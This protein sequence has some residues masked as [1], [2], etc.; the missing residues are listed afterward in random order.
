MSL[1][2]FIQRK[3]IHGLG[4]TLP[5][6]QWHTFPGVLGARVSFTELTRGNLETLNF[7]KMAMINLHELGFCNGFL[8][9]TPK[10][11]GTKGNR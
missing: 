3:T 6:K 11:Q 9:M 1:M 4:S 8:G 2:C 10:V 5:H 7:V